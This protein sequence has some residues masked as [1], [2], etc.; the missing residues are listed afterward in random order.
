VFRKH[1]KKR[2]SGF[3]DWDQLKHCKD[4]LLFPENVGKHLSIDEVSLSKGELYTFVTNRQG[5]VKIK[6]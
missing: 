3:K 6:P 5:E 1:Y 4:Y 2:L